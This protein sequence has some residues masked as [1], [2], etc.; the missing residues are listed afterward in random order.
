MVFPLAGRQI[1]GQIFNVPAK[2]DPKV[3]AYI[4]EAGAF[5]QPVLKHLRKLVHA[6]CPEVEE[7]IK[8]NHISFGYRGKILSGMAAFKE[9]LSFGFWH[10]QMEKI[11]AQDG[12]KTGDA[13]GLMGRITGPSDLPDDKTMLRYIRMAVALHDSG[14]PARKRPAP[15]PKAPLR[16]PADLASGLKSNKKA[17]ATWENFSYSA[18]KEYI[19]WLTEAK[20]EETRA[21]RLASTIEWLA[22]GKSRN[23]KY[24][25]C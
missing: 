23:W 22:A 13:M 12:F 2:T 24:E 6:G 3:D 5:A 7:S 16:V 1:S 15:K 25:N 11:L 9:H 21:K 17:A 20:R 14:A 10:Q 4:A 19:E 18:R 8:W